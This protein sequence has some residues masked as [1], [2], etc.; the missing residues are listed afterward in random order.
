MTAN[1]HAPYLTDPQGV[2]FLWQG[3]VIQSCNI[4]KSA[5]TSLMCG[6]VIF[7]PILH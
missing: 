7:I 1:A 5:L 4:D 6:Y 3:W 2:S